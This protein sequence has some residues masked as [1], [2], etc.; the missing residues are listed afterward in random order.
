MLRGRVRRAA[1]AASVLGILA[2]VAP[3]ALAGE[4][5][6]A[7]SVGDSHP[8][9]YDERGDITAVGARYHGDVLEL[10]M[11]V[12]EAI[13]FGTS[14]W[15]E[16][17]NVSVGWDLDELPGRPG[18]TVLVRLSASPGG[19]TLRVD[20]EPCA[21]ATAEVRGASY[22]VR[23]PL[24]CIGD[25]DRVAVSA[26]LLVD[27]IEGVG[28]DLNDDRVPNEWD[29]RIGPVVRGG[30]TPSP[31]LRAIDQACP[32]GRVQAAGFPDVPAGGALRA[33]V[34]CVVWWGVATGRADG[35]YG[36][37]AL[38]TRGQMASFLARA[39]FPDHQPYGNS[40]DDDDGSA[41]EGAIQVLASQHVVA[42][43]GERRFDPDGPVTRDQLAT[44]LWRF[45]RSN[46]LGGAQGNHFTDD[47][48]SSHQY[49]VNV[50]AGRGL[51][52]GAEGTH[53]FPSRPV[54]RAEMASFM[55]RVLDAAVE[56][57]AL[58]PP[59]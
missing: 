14:M 42:G 51:A 59:A 32:P 23:I 28:G 8:Y 54:T 25:P 27:S 9:F 19:P 35:T 13:P 31:P 7:D 58:R 37:D 18:E 30:P 36:P 6:F 21:G 26:H 57:G 39:L 33:D 56:G 1:M 47:D 50:I 45:M 16:D 53:Y 15:F 29:S 10:T 12:V 24:G 4:A 40:F 20:R 34:D 3:P 48:G 11:T 46:G 43:K 2:V 17:L 55:A 49:P 41:H 52:V 5:T 38:V 22:V 44:F